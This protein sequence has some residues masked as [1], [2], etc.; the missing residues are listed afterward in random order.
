[1]LQEH[2]DAVSQALGELKSSKAM[3]YR[4]PSAPDGNGDWMMNQIYFPG[5][6]G[7]YLTDS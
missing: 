3:R 5:A 1:M 2:L 7:Q 4:E 6:N